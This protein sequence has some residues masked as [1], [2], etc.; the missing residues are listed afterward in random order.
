MLNEPK[1]N[2][3][4][5]AAGLGRPWPSGG[6][7]FCKLERGLTTLWVLLQETRETQLKRSASSNSG[8]GR[9]LPILSFE[10]I[11]LSKQRQRKSVLFQE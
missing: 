2:L 4:E 5:A 6:R 11:I 9:N 1:R 7:C 10:H 8:M 3:A